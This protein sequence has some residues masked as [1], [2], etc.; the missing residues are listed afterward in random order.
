MFKKKKK[1]GKKKAYQKDIESAASE[2]YF[3]F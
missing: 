1:A 3:R 2:S